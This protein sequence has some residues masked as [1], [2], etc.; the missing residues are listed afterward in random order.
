MAAGRQHRPL[1][2]PAAGA[3]SRP[4]KSACADNPR[5]CSP[6]S[7]AAIRFEMPGRRRFGRRSGPA[8]N[9]LVPIAPLLLAEIKFF[10]RY[11]GGAISDGVVRRLVSTAPLLFPQQGR[12]ETLLNSPAAQMRSECSL[13]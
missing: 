3:A 6:S 9:G 7:A 4:A 1:L 2:G 11:K 10:G 12:R 5:G 8:T 13:K